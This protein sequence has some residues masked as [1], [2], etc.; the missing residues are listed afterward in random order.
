[1][2]KKYLLAALLSVVQFSVVSAQKTADSLEIEKMSEV[3]VN[4]VKTSPNAPF[5]VT[6]IGK[7]VLEQFSGTGQELPLLL[8]QTPGIVAWSENG[9]GTGTTYMRIRGAGDSRIT[10]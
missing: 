3:V 9:V 6:N 8:S 2:H 1:M 7:K 5:A 10:S 4:A